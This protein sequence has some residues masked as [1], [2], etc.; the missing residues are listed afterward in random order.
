MTS[1]IPQLLGT[2]KEAEYHEVG[3]HDSVFSMDTVRL[4]PEAS[5]SSIQIH[6]NFC[7]CAPE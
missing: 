7:C 3:P 6:V 4:A 5:Y 2:L 1:Q